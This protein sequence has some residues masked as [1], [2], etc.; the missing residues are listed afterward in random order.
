VFAQLERETIQ[1]RVADAYHS[2]TRKGFRMGKTPYGYTTEPFV[3]QG[4]STK[5]LTADP[6]AAENIRLMYELYAQ[7]DVSLGD[8][9]RYFSERGIQIHGK[10]LFKTN[11]SEMLMNPVYVQADMDIYDFFKSNGTY[12]EGDATDFT[13]VTGCC[14]YQS[15][16]QPRDTTRYGLQNRVLVHRRMRGLYRRICG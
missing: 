5:R 11:I 2:R 6:A 14:L 12:I 10:F 16:E 9:A 13:G 8:V 4:I 1:R 7:P 15:K 3:I